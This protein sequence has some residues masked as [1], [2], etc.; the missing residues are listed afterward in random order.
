VLPDSKAHGWNMN[1]V[2]VLK[3]LLFILCCALGFLGLR[4]RSLYMWD[5]VMSIVLGVYLVLV[6]HTLAFHVQTSVGRFSLF[7][8]SQLVSVLIL[9]YENLFGC[10]I[11]FFFFW[12]VRT[13]QVIR[14]F[15]FFMFTW[16]SN[17]VV[18]AY[19]IKVDSQIRFSQSGSH[20]FQKLE[21]NLIIFN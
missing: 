20:I 1:W 13:D 14:I 2:L 5:F 15:K 18:L 6:A 21:F 11:Y 7:C 3:F 10:L 4:M 8:E 12:L 17:R 9:C 19:K 16:F